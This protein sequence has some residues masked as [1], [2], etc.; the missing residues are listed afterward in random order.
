MKIGF[1]YHVHYHGQEQGAICTYELCEQLNSLGHDARIYAF[2]SAGDGHEGIRRDVR[3]HDLGQLTWWT[4][5]GL[6]C[7]VF[8]TADAFSAQV[9]TQA[10]DAGATVVIESDSDGYIS[11]RQAPFHVLRQKMW[12][13][14]YSSL[15]KLRLL[16]TWVTLALKSAATE[17]RIFD[18]FSAA[19]FVKIESE[20]PKNILRQFL[21]SKSRA[22]LAAKVIVIPFP[23]RPHFAHDAVEAKR[24]PMVIAAGRLDS[25]QK[26][27]ELLA[28]IL[29]AFCRSAP[30]AAVE[31]HIRGLSTT[32]ETLA[33]SHQRIAVF[34]DSSTHLLARRLSDARVFL[35]TSRWESTPIAAIE[36]LCMGCSLVAPDDVPG[37]RSLINNGRYGTAYSRGHVDAGVHALKSE[38]EQ[39]DTGRRNPARTAMHWRMKSSLQAVA[40]RWSELV[41][42]HR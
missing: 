22:D 5:E 4:H 18:S 6:D 9:L 11:F 13:S 38:L 19:H 2:G 41:C 42:S 3:L 30:E 8:Y 37:Y 35:S 24:R 31:I 26:N 29:A 15:L 40:N 21:L 27:A 16:K 20:E 28:D 17:R 12:D 25:Q 10:R 36:A 7:A 32:L 14:R 39:W 34:H 33:K 23:V 1:I